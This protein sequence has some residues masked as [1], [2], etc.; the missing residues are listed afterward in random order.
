MAKKISPA[1]RAAAEAHL[2]SLGSSRESLTDR[3]WQVVARHARQRRFSTLA[4]VL[5]VAFAAAHLWAAHRAWVYYPKLLA[6][7]ASAI[8]AGVQQAADSN[9]AEPPPELLRRFAQ[10]S[11]VF[12]LRIV[13]YLAVG[14]G[15][16]AVPLL[17]ALSS[18]RTGRMISAFL[19]PGQPAE[20]AAL[21]NPA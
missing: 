15:F 19:S 11:L 1:V 18:R 10:I 5:C 8:P 2:A 17:S 20:T 6:E 3:Q 14:F 21:D 9:P 16:L 13:S 7:L 4:L 12:A